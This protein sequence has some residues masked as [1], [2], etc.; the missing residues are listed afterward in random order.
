MVIKFIV[1]FILL[2]FSAF[3]NMAEII[4]TS[5][6]KWKLEKFIKKREEEWAD[7][8]SRLLTTVLVGTDIVNLSASAIASVIALDVF[9]NKGIAIAT[10]IMIFIIL[11]FCEITPKI[12]SK[13]HVKAISSFIIRTLLIFD[14]L[15]YPV[16]K[17]L[18]LLANFLIFL[19]RGK[20]IKSVPFIT[21]EELRGLVDI[22]EKEGVLEREEREMLHS[23]FEFGDKSVSEVMKYTETIVAVKEGMQLNE[24]LTIAIESGY[25]R[26]PVYREDINHI[27]GIIYTKDLLSIWK[28]KDLIKLQDIVREPY[29]VIESMKVKNLLKQFQIRKIHMGIVV[30]EKNETKGLVTFEDLVEEIVGE[31]HDEYDT[32]L[33]TGSYF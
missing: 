29:F 19:F 32:I 16:T 15:F 23:V 13:Q 22:G 10:G 11:F 21:E 17:I 8:I 28:N 2:L 9:G 5:L 31:I 20:E 12:F 30:D 4:L 7:E 14:K 24:I 18:V 3:F 1:L 25:S 33:G 27:V 26:I 6:D